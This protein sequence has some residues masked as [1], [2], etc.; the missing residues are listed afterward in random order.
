MTALG[1]AAAALALLAGP[2]IAQE[3]PFT[4][5]NAPLTGRETFLAIVIVAM[6]LCGLASFFLAGRVAER[7]Q[8]AFA[9]FA[10]LIGGFGL[11]VLFGW[12]IYDYP[13]VAVG[14]ILLM[15]GLFKLMNQFETARRGSGPKSGDRKDPP[16]TPDRP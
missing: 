14:M 2:A 1:T 5:S 12:L 4:I 6:M 11:L 15:I 13:I 9:M 10:V 8:T 16:D 7:T 3:A